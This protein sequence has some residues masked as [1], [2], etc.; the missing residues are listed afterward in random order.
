[1]KEGMVVNNSGLVLGFLNLAYIPLNQSII[2]SFVL[3]PPGL[4][5]FAWCQ[6]RPHQ[7]RRADSFHSHQGPL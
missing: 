5:C 2:K 4:P 7:P 6:R 3:V 1:M